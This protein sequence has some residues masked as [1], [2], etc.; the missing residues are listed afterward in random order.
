MTIKLTEIRVEIL[1]EASN[2]SDR[3]YVAIFD[4][5]TARELELE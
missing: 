2:E 5:P 1:R 4:D 3:V